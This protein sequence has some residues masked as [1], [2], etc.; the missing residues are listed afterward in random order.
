MSIEEALRRVDE[1]E[2]AV[3]EA[4]EQVRAAVGARAAALRQARAAG[5][6][7]STLGERIG[8]TLQRAQQ[9]SKQGSD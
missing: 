1:A 5:A 4:H 3:A 7:W 6:T 2:A 8:V 9:M